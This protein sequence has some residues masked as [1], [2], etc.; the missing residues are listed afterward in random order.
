MDFNAE[1]L[2]DSLHRFQTRIVLNSKFVKLVKFLTDATE[3]CGLILRQSTLFPQR[4][5]PVPESLGN[6]FLHSRQG[7][8]SR[9]TLILPKGSVSKR[10]L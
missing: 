10:L 2:G 7:A 5:Q 6:V 3:F 1:P 9:L 4:S 8:F